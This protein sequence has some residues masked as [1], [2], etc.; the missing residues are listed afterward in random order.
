M[1]P[2]PT[3][4]AANARGSLLLILALA[5]FTVEITVIKLLGEH[6]AL[7]QL[8]LWRSASQLVLLMP[9]FVTSRGNVLRTG[10]SRLHLVRGAL[11]GFCMF[12]LFYAFSNLP[13][14]F[15]TAISF[16]QPLFMVPMA[17]LLLGESVTRAG[18]R[19]RPWA[20]SA[21]SW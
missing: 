20:S 15:A 10:I 8:V 5:L 19:P 7:L 11:S 16:T 12:A 6:H 3:T 2:A 9:L 17:V 14:A 21:R 4:A 18:S 1:T 13:L